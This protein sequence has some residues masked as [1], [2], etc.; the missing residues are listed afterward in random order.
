[1]DSGLALA[2]TCFGLQRWPPLFCR[3]T[4]RIHS[5][6]ILLT[7]TTPTTANLSTLQTDAV[8]S[9]PLPLHPTT[10]PQSQ[11]APRS[12]SRS[13]T[14]SLT[15][16]APS[17]SL[18]PTTS[19]STASAPAPSR[20]STK[21]STS[22]TTTS[23]TILRHHQAGLRHQQPRAH[24][25]RDRHHGGL[26]RVPPYLPAHHHFRH[27]DQVVAVMPYHRNV[28]FRVSLHPVISIRA[29][30]LAFRRN[31][32]ATSPY[33]ASRPT[34]AACSEPYATFTPAPS[35]TAT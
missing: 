15:S 16:R 33:P 1:M 34:F 14:R 10:S 23:G 20:P 26:Q 13:R 12:V 18:P 3:S 9:V 4:L 24:T 25:E 31:C 27:T 32:T 2:T 8:P 7:L 11:R 29:A 17:P 35:S 19:S 5:R 6:S 21:P 28:D 22:A 30:D